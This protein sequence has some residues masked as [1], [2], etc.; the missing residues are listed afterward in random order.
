MH[1]GFEFW[2]FTYS[3]PKGSKKTPTI[4]LS[5]HLKPETY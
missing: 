2:N 4:D 1:S 5:V 3:M